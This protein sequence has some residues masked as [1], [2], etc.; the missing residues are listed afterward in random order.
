MKI[1][2]LTA[3]T[4]VDQ[5][6]N[7]LSEDIGAGDLTA[8]LIPANKQMSGRV[9]ARENGVLAGS[10]WF[11]EVFRQVD[12]AVAITWLATDGDLL[13][14]N[15]PLCTLKG[16]ARALL[17]G[18]RTALNFIQLL[19]AVATRTASYVDAVSSSNCKI[20]DTRKTI[21]GLRLAQKYAVLCGGG[22]NHRIGLFDA[23]LI[24]ENHIASAGSIAAAVSLARKQARENATSANQQLMVEVEVESLNELAQAIAAGADRILLDNFSLT[25]LET[26]VKTN[27]GR[28]ELEAS[29]G[30]T[31]ETI[32]PIADTGVDF[33]SVGELTKTI[34]AL[35]LSMRL[36]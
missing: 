36:E 32:G 4:L 10:E 7:A 19:S 31:L 18:E 28:S 25:D 1:D 14:A 11:N 12:P 15:Q 22:K 21:P 26:A 5:V 33:I 34:D 6:K 3:T 17:T 35:D 29:G 23:V 27:A 24:K 16:P 2:S 9:I 30:I 8:A 13:S 20:L